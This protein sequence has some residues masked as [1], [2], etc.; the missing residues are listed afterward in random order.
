MR[1][2]SNDDGRG[3]KSIFSR[4]INDCPMEDDEPERN[5]NVKC[6]FNVLSTVHTAEPEAQP[7]LMEHG[8]AHISTMTHEE[9]QVA[10]RHILG[11]SM[12]PSA[13]R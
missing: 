13:P 10:L 12:D 2:S 11:A 4:M 5:E 3:N 6:F 9:C 7:C 1:Q 8:D